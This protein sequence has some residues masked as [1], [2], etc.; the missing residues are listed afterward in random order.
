VF[1]KKH[2][3]EALA[4][5][6][7]YNMAAGQATP[8]FRLEESKALPKSWYRISPPDGKE[9]RCVPGFGWET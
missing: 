6:S 7:P 4:A 3:H 8:N 2:M 9:E 5:I 1:N